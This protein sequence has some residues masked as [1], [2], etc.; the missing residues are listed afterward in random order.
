[1]VVVAK[2]N[3]KMIEVGKKRI[4]TKVETFEDLMLTTNGDQAKKQAILDIIVNKP[5]LQH[6]QKYGFSIYDSG[7]QYYLNSDPEFYLQVLRILKD[8]VSF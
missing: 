4:I 2:S 1:M 8:Q 5:E 6:D 7:I 3:T